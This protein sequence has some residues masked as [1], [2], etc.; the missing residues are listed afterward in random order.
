MVEQRD[1]PFEI[2]QTY[3]FEIIHMG[4]NLAQPD[5][6]YTASIELVGSVPSGI[7]LAIVDDH[8][9]LGDRSN[10]GNATGRFAKKRKTGQVT[11]AQ[12]G[13]DVREKAR[14][15]N[16]MPYNDP[17]M[18]DD[19]A[20][21]R[22]NLLVW[23][24]NEGES[25]PD[26]D[27]AI[28]L[29]KYPEASDQYYEI[30]KMVYGPFFGPYSLKKGVVTDTP[31]TEE[32]AFVGDAELQWAP[33]FVIKYGPSPDKLNGGE[34][35]I[36]A[37]TL[38]EYNISRNGYRCFYETNFVTDDAKIRDLNRALNQ[39]FHDGN[40][41]NVRKFWR[42]TTF[43]ETTTPM[44]ALSVTHNFGATFTEKDPVEILGKKYPVAEVTMPIYY[45]NADMAT[46]ALIRNDEEFKSR[47]LDFINSTLK[48][49]DID[50]KYDSG[51]GGEQPIRFDFS[52]AYSL[53][54]EFGGTGSVGLGTVKVDFG[55]PYYGSGHINLM[56]TKVGTTYNI[57]PNPS[58]S[59]IMEDVWDY[60]YF[61]RG[62][63][64]T[65]TGATRVASTIQCGHGRPGSPETEGGNVGQVALVR[66]D[67]EGPV[68]VTPAAKPEP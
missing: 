43:G 52:G 55:T 61:S 4:S 41:D 36:F 12:A 45:W 22:N 14:P 25:R 66:I 38:D 53:R 21:A 2:G 48:Y 3:E 18:V 17:R 16:R 58:V 27:I 28:E 54:F 49:S 32:L 31:V 64:F 5:F 42:P 13:L 33:D 56:V 15:A 1:Y 50:A 7:A 11:L 68:G 23:H 44:S 6:D 67:L 19:D 65:F 62:L 35:S 47:I 20:H 46:N 63:L 34:Y 29:V 40:W 24:L 26:F 37:V 9:I 30:I 57:A 60:N 10:Q 51:V 59:M 39:R 8:E